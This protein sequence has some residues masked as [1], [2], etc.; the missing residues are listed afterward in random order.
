MIHESNV[1]GFWIR[2]YGY[3]KQ[4][5]QL[6]GQKND[7][8][9]GHKKPC[10]IS[11]VQNLFRLWDYGHEHVV[12]LS[13]EQASNLIEHMANNNTKNEKSSIINPTNVIIASWTKNEKK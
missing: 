8:R 5:H 9:S 13:F 12:I 2:V 4:P 3:W 10:T 1:G 11:N 6:E 7:E